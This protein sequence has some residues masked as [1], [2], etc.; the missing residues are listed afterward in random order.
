LGLLPDGWHV[1]DGAQM[2]H[3]FCVILDVKL[4]QVGVRLAVDVLHGDLEPVKGSRFRPFD[5]FHETKGQ[6]L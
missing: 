2:L 4:Q 6:V 1:V 3:A 5:V